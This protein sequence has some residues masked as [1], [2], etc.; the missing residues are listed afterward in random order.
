MF[1]KSCCQPNKEL[2]IDFKHL[3][4]S[5]DYNVPFIYLKKIYPTVMNGEGDRNMERHIR[6]LKRRNIQD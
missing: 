3:P 5:P 1:S 6:S 2:E 4:S